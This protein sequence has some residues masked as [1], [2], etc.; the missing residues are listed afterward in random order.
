MPFHFLVFCQAAVPQFPIDTCL[1]YFTCVFSSRF[2]VSVFHYRLPAA[3]E[4]LIHG[5]LL[6]FLFSSCCLVMLLSQ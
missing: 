1:L 5:Y 4:N 6:Q 2:L 3:Q